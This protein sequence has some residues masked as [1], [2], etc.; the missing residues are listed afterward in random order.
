[1][2]NLQIFESNAGLRYN[3]LVYLIKIDDSNN[4]LCIDKNFSCNS[5]EFH[6]GNV[7]EYEDFKLSVSEYKIEN[8]PIYKT[9]LFQYFLKN[10]NLK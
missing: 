10:C 4:Y 3:Q 7:Y 5:D 2:K 9:F 1:M 6:I 8:S